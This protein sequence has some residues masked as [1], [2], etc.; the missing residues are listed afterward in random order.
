MT[1]VRAFTS[2]GIRAA[3]EMLTELRTGAIEAP[4]YD[5]LNSAQNSVD[6]Q[7]G[8]SDP[9]VKSLPTRWDLANWLMSEFYSHREALTAGTWSWLAMHLFHI[10]CPRVDGDREV[11]ND[12]RY[13]LQEHDYRRSYR[14][15]LAG[16]YLLL[17]A[18]RDE[19]E[20][21]RGL[22]A[23][24]PSAPGD[25]YERLV[26]RK[27]LVTSRAAVKVATLLY[28][29][30]TS[31]QLRRGAGGK[32]PGSVRRFNEVLQQL[33]MTNDLNEVSPERLATLLP[34]EFLR[35]LNT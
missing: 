7:F 6:L 33:E 16:P 12:T 13:L 10:L 25:V 3:A 19:P 18:H 8:F 21:T 24:A 28:L 23:T 34:K 20:I 2:A 35:Y 32:G 14:H 29:D 15:L 27:S 22:L 9:D 11:F 30:Q 1:T 4:N 26:S 5:V 31:F 17:E